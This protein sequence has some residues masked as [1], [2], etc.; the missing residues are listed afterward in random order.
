MLVRRDDSEVDAT[1][2][3][4]RI[5]IISVIFFILSTETFRCHR[6]ALGEREGHFVGKIQEDMEQV[7]GADVAASI[8]NRYL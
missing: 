8:S 5:F 1:G 3:V 2:R 6:F 4:G 7:V